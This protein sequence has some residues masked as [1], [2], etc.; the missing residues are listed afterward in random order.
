MNN[1]KLKK[2]IIDVIAFFDL[3][4]CPLTV[5]EIWKYLNLKQE[6]IYSISKILDSNELN[7]IISQKNG[8]YFLVG[9]EKIVKLRINEYNLSCEKF[10]IGLKAAQ[11]LRYINGVKMVAICNNIFYKKESDIDFFIITSPNRIWLTRLLVTLIIHFYGLRRYDKKIADKI[12]LSFYISEN[13][14]NLKDITLKSDPYFY[15]WLANLY[16]LYISSQSSAERLRRERFDCYKIFLMENSWIKKYLPNIFNKKTS[17]LRSVS[18]NIFSIMLKK[19]NNLWFSGMMGNFLEKKVKKAQ[20]K[21]MVKNIIAQ[22]E[23]IIVM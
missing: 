23:K 3:F 20:L 21:K 17:Y 2:A 14:M 5:F 8:F 10:K 19:I 12:C 16:P 4:N 6:T 15:I 11:K 9:K 18:D 1:N 13:K 22:L 7:N